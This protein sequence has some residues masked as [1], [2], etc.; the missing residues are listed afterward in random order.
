V[1][2]NP[3]AAGVPDYVALDVKGVKGGQLRYTLPGR[4]NDVAAMLLD[5]DKADGHRAWARRYEMLESGNRRVRARWVFRG[6]MGIQPTVE[7]DFRAVPEKNG[8]IVRYRL[9]KKSFGVAAFFGDHRVVGLH[10]TPPSVE[11]TSRVFIDSGLKLF[12][13][14]RADIEKGLRRDAELMRAWMISRLSPAE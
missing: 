12:N 4:V 13:A 7:I 2:L 11:V 5:F 10:T 14:S 9:S 1:D 6:K 8:V 3:E